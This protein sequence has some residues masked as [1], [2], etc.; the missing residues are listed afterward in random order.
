MT[1]RLCRWGF[2][3]TATIGKKNWQAV[4]K[5]GNATLAAVASRNV[6]R[7]QQFIDECQSQVPFATPPKAVGSYEAMLAD[8][9]ID[10]VYIPLP[11]GLRKE[12]VIRAAEAGK[13]VLCEKPCGVSAA[14]VRE[15]TDACERHGVQFMDG[16][17]FMHS[18]RLGRLRDVLDDGRSVGHIKRIASQFS[19]FGGDE[20]RRENIRVHS[21]L[22]PLGCLG[23]L[24]WYNLRFS[25]WAMGW[26]T[27][28]HVT[29]RSLSELRRGDSPHTVPVEFSGELFFPDGASASFYCSF[30][31]QNQQWANISG[32]KGYAHL[33]DFVLPF[34]G[35][36]VAFSVTSAEAKFDVCDFA[37]EEHTRRFEVHERSHSA[38]H[39]QESNMIRA[40]S[41]LA[42]SGRPDLHWPRIAVQTQAV[43]DACLRSAKAGGAAVEVR[44]E[45]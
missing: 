16:V 14:D 33:P 3:S 19:F 27:P 1:D 28:T 12:W 38:A 22:E 24:G 25:L 7:A 42:L 10:A 20:F 31:T 40:F 17:M 18:G 44:S 29:G 2:L 35:S 15:M 23:D 43:L 21:E 11:T 45:G 9:A 39:S 5:A 13:H 4:R 30:I 6:G 41:K 37:M 26:Q 32:T 34:F 36:E 8:D